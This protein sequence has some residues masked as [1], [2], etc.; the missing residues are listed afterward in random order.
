MS[1]KPR[2]IQ[3]RRTEGY[4]ASTGHRTVWADY[5][6][7]RFVIRD[8]EGRWYS[9]LLGCFTH[10]RKRA[11]VMHLSTARKVLR[12]MWGLGKQRLRAEVAKQ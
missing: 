4:P 3:R 11:E 2:R 10:N 6:E 12:K 9:L 5:A 7:Q 1:E 8:A